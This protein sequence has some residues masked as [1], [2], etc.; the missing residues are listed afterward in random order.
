MKRGAAQSPAS[1]VTSLLRRRQHRR[2]LLRLIHGLALR[3]A[4]GLRDADCDGSHLPRADEAG[5]LDV[6]HAVLRADGV[7]ARVQALVVE[8]RE[9]GEGVMLA[10]IIQIQSV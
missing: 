9:L 3:Q 6:G 8:R 2:P 4:P 7:K 1:P 5:L 10:L